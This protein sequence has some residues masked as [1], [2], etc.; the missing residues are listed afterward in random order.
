LHRKIDFGKIQYNSTV[1][2]FGESAA[3]AASQL[4]RQPSLHMPID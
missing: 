3:E 4:S 2:V 1:S